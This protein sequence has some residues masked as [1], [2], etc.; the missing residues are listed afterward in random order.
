MTGCRNQ[1]A[2]TCAPCSGAACNCKG[3]HGA[4]QEHQAAPVP[5]LGSSGRAAKL[6]LST[7]LES[8]DRS[9][10]LS[11]ARSVNFLCRYCAGG[12]EPALSPTPPSRRGL[13]HGGVG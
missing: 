3:F 1:L 8:A 13:R 4:L 11:S 10:A 2:K 7:T 6:A 9:C 12:V 5:T